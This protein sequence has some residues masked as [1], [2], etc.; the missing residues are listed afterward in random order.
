MSRAHLR[1]QPLER[2]FHDADAL[3]ELLDSA[4]HALRGYASE[5]V[6]RRSESQR[7]SVYIDCHVAPYTGNAEGWLLVEFSDVTPRVRMSRDNR[8]RSQHDVGRVIIRQLAHE[9]KN[10]LGGLRGAAQLLERHVDDPAL[11]EYTGVIVHEVDRLAALV[12][13]LLGPGGTPRKVEVN[14]HDVLEHVIR[15]VSVDAGGR[16]EW[17]RDYDPSLPMLMLD[18]DQ[19]I[20]AVL[21]IVQNAVAAGDGGRIGVSLR[22]RALTNETIGATP[23]RVIASIEIIDDGPGIDPEIRDSIFYPLVTG[24]ADGTGLGLPLSQELIQRHD[25][26]IE[27]TSEPGY[28]VFEIRLPMEQAS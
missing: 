24:R 1:G 19:M 6:L 21:N 4:R 22:T 3:H 23:H 20:Q 11:A 28:T 14:I 27:F 5:L 16:V 10:P 15:L 18:R 7:E 9:I 12:D 2:Y 13:S 17:R 26:L 25:G 8:L